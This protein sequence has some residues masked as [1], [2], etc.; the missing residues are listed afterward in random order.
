MLH[1][2]PGDTPGV[3]TQASTNRHLSIIGGGAHAATS[4]TVARRV[5]AYAERNGNSWTLVSPTRALLGRL[6]ADPE[7][8]E[9]TEQFCGRAKDYLRS[10]GIGVENSTTATGLR[11]VTFYAPAIPRP[12]L[13]SGMDG[14]VTLIEVHAAIVSAEMSGC[15]AP[16]TIHRHCPPDRPALRAVELVFAS[17]PLGV[18]AVDSWARHLEAPAG[19]LPAR[20]D[21]GRLCRRYQLGDLR[22]PVGHQPQIAPGWCVVAWASVDVLDCGVQP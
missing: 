4:A 22:I 13:E 12:P 20:L 8:D 7:D 2:V 9:S 1:T 17:G 14:A 19:F 10:I 3:E 18:D 11:H 15:A 6:L 5:V 16:V 21:R